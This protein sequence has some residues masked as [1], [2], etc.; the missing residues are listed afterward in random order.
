MVTEPILFLLRYTPFWSVPIFIIAGQFSYIYWLKGYRKISLSLAS[1]VLISFVVTLFY[2]WAG[3]PD[4][5]PQ[6]FLKLIR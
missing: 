1:L 2:I 3:G 4:N 5:T 6:M